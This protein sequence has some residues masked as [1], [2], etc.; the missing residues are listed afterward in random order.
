MGK[1]SAKLLCYAGQLK[2]CHDHDCREVASVAFDSSYPDEMRVAIV[3]F[4]PSSMLH[5]H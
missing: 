1:E 3:F 4:T 5:E 2:I